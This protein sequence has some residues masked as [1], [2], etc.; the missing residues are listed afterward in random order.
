MSGNQPGEES[1]L[2]TLGYMLVG[3]IIIAVLLAATIWFVG[4]VLLSYEFSYRTVFWPLFIW[5]TLMH[6]LLIVWTHHFMRV[7]QQQ[8][9]LGKRFGTAVEI[10][11]DEV[12]FRPP[13][14]TLRL[15]I[16]SRLKRD[17]PLDLW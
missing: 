4:T 8:V 15:L 3:W 14:W 7:L 12:R 1:L 16:R 11:C 13:R 6:G 9:T 5:P 2:R 10:A 17:H